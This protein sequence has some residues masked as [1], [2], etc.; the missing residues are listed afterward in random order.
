MT[1]GNSGG[2]SI[3][4]APLIALMLF[5]GGLLVQHQP[6]QSVRPVSQAR[7]LTVP[8]YGQ[9]VE[10]RLWQ[11]PLEAVQQADRQEAGSGK[12]TPEE[13]SAIC[14]HPLAECHTPKWLR[15]ELQTEIRDD[16]GRTLVLPVMIFGGPYAEDSEDRSRTRYAVLSYLIDSGYQPVYSRGIGYVRIGNAEAQAR[17]LPRLIPFERWES[18]AGTAP[19]HGYAHVLVLWL[20]EESFVPGATKNLQYLFKHV[21]P[22]EGIAM[23][24]IGPNSQ[25]TADELWPLRGAADSSGSKCGDGE[26]AVWLGHC[27]EIL[28]PRLTTPSESP[29]A[30]RF[31]PNDNQIVRTLLDEL[32]NRGL[33]LP[34]VPDSDECKSDDKS[35]DHI[36]IVV[37]ADTH[38]GRSLE[39]EFRSAVGCKFETKPSQKPHLHVFRYFRGLDGKTSH[40]SEEASTTSDTAGPD[41]K[42]ET[43]APQERAQGQS[44][45]D[46]LLRVASWARKQNDHLES[47]AR[48]GWSPFNFSPTGRSIRAV[49]V[50]GSDVYDKLAIL[51][52]LREHLPQA[53]FA[54]TDLDAAFLQNDQLRWTRNLVVAS[55]YDLRLHRPKKGVE[56]TEEGAK[57]TEEDPQNGAPPFRDTYQTA[58]FVATNKALSQPG[59]KLDIDLIRTRA[60][61][62]PMLFEIGDGT[63]VKLLPVGG[64]AK[65]QH[66]G[67]GVFH[68]VA[69]LGL[70]LLFGLALSWCLRKLLRE[71]W[72]ILTLAAVL[73]GA[74]AYYMVSV[75]GEAGEEPL[76]WLDGVSIWPSEFIRLFVVLLGA[77]LFIYARRHLTDG[78]ARIAHEFF[79]R[80]PPPSPPKKARLKVCW[81]HLR[82][83]FSAPRAALRRTFP[84][85]S[86]D[87]VRES[88]EVKALWSDYR[89]WTSAT[90]VAVRVVIGVV[91]YVLLSGA[92]ISMYPLITPARGAVSFRL[93]LCTTLAANLIVALTL[94]AT[95]GRVA[96]STLFLHRLFGDGA[97]AIASDWDD[98]VLHRFCGVSCKAS[99]SYVDLMLSAR[100]TEALDDIV[101]FPFLL[102]VLLF[103]ARS[104]LFDNWVTP[105]G[106]MGV[107]GF[108][109]VLVVISAFALRQ[110]AER[111]RRYTIEQLTKI[112]VRM[113]G[114]HGPDEDK[115]CNPETVKLMR[116]V[117]TNL[118]TGAFAPLSEQPIVRALILP[119]GGAGALSI[120]EYLLM[121]KG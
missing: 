68:L 80:D 59:D 67:P 29:S 18:I 97:V 43:T 41:A 65:S 89:K 4:I 99:K 49:V 24:I 91:L 2:S 94:V 84:R 53:I 71:Y 76:H 104:P 106:L 27:V 42:K 62:H 10:A 98:D 77:M 83:C 96:V 120:L 28:A 16:P 115:S 56:G 5:A 102:T 40:K 39:R 111:I 38:Y 117:A 8:H 73:V 11:D 116:E 69:G 54:T 113:R 103:V 37:E 78:E 121:A 109:L 50:L 45:F 34:R 23:K 7:V 108:A 1:Q 22:D 9:D 90:T 25:E 61:Q 13:R 93:D 55:G 31:S 110:S 112:E 12:G 47:N 88:V 57:G 95:L 119:F 86:E 52:A 92:L 6:L 101:L 60:L 32:R 17:G 3:P 21:L 79:R 51:H 19:A 15:T 26:A 70:T 64:E 100:L 81:N 58:T 114:G 107:V 72:R 35:L 46:Y 14:G 85:Y 75:S 36:A 118:R 63:A 48:E 74:Y 66:R 20:T 82:A 44:Q 87:V 33:K 105:W 30:L